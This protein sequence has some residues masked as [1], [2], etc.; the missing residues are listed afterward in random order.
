MHGVLGVVVPVLVSPLFLI[1]IMSD[2][3]DARALGYQPPESA[4][5]RARRAIVPRAPVHE[6]DSE[7]S[8]G[9]I[10]T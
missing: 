2:V 6:V 10:I 7:A 1:Q 8:A 4:I 9:A 5:V 3:L